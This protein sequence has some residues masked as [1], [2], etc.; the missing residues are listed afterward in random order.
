MPSLGNTLAALKRSAKADKPPERGKG[1]LR[2]GGPFE[3]NPGALVMR[4]HVPDGL[5]A[6]VP[7]VVVLHGCGQTADDYAEGSGWITLADRLG[8][9]LVCPEQTRANNPNRCFN[10]YEPGDVARGEGE[11]ASVVAMVRHAV[12]EYDLDPDR[13]FVTGLSAGGAMTAA[14]LATYPELFAGGAVIAGLPYGSARSMAEAFMA[15]N[16]GRTE[17]A[18]TAGDHVRAASAHAGPWPPISIWHGQS[19]VVVKPGAGE[20]LARQWANVHGAAEPPV[21]A[22]TPTGRDFLVWLSPDGR[23]VV[24]LHRIAAMGHGA[25]LST[26]G[27]DGSGTAGP[28]MLEVGVSSSLEIAMGWGIA[29]DPRTTA[30]IKPSPSLKPKTHAADRAARRPALKPVVHPTVNVTAIIEQAMRTAGL[31]K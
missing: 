29:D 3:P 7:L 1:R 6:K 13:V 5:A 30:E 22:R 4:V 28:Y 26:G 16:H 24:E 11:A 31:M 15:M 8:F 21:T 20:A 27:P 19:D 25:P 23:P 12:A 10:W 9:A 18:S 17:T 2:D 14:L